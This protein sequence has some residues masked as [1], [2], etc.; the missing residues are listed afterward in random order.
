MTEWYKSNKNDELKKKY[1]K[2]EFKKDNKNN[3]KCT[4][5][6]K[7][8]LVRNKV[9]IQRHLKKKGMLRAGFEPALFIVIWIS[10]F[11]SP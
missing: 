2:T 6:E 9:K 1:D 7:K 4:D 10:L 5:E 3:N 11:R 8:Q